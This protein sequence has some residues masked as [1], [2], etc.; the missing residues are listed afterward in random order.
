M[1]ANSA[2]RPDLA[3]DR[4]V[5]IA[6]AAVM[7]VLAVPAHAGQQA[8]L[9]PTHRELTIGVFE[10]PPFAMK[11]PQGSWVGISVDLWRSVAAELK[12]RFRFQEMDLDA[13][14]AGVAEGLIDLVVAPIGVNS[15]REKL[16]DFSHIY[17]VT[18]LGIA[19]VKHSEADRWLDVL[20]AFYSL[21]YLR[22]LLGIVALL[23]I[24][25]FGIWLVERKRNP[26]AFGGDPLSGI[27]AGFWFSSVTF[28]GAPFG[29]KVP[30]TL[31]GKIFAIFW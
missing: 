12:L 5:P 30:V 18:G 2:G 24:V 19:F 25:G 28:T 17:F 8:K 20:R 22:D 6:L 1:P 26:E 13:S 29:D 7:L 11:D 10:S 9:P 3:K 4:V 23:L 21:V 16:V 15:E 31:G 27:A 14:L